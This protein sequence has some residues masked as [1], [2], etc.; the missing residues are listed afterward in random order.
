[1]KYNKEIS[2]LE[3][4]SLDFNKLDLCSEDAQSTLEAALILAIFVSICICIAL[5]WQSADT[6]FTQYA[7]RASSHSLEGGIRDVQDV[8]SF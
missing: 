4:S 5:L 1:M 6:D 8:I 7:Q 2:L 3:K